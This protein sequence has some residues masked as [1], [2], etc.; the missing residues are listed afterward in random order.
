MAI[1][2]YRIQCYLSRRAGCMGGGGGF[3]QPVGLLPGPAANCISA[4]GA[5]SQPQLWEETVR[6]THSYPWPHSSRP[7]HAEAPTQQWRLEMGV[8]V[9]IFQN[10][11]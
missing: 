2:R 3:P 4:Q 9:G 10:I 6:K 11:P 8:F 5:V 7:F 1:L